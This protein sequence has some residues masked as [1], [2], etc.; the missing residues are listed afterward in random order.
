VFVDESGFNLAMTPSHG[1]APKGQQA[2]GRVP[3]NRGENTSLVAALSLD[4]GV[5][6]AMTLTG[7]VDGMAFEVYIRQLLC[8]QPRSGQ[9]VVMDRLGVHKASG[10]RAAIEAR[11]CELVFL[12]S[13]SP[14]L[15]PIELAFSKLKTYVK[16]LAA[17]TRSALDSDIAA[18]LG[19]VSLSDVRS[20]FEH[21]GY[22]CHS[23]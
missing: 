23:F 16:R 14:D 9:I 6:A 13:Y 21:A 2:V 5:T 11:G 4:M 10:V 3:K 15:N 8:P 20:W 19:S 17:R 7:A 12:P 22:S 18:A 1:Y